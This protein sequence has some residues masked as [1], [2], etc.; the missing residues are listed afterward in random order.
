M[1]ELAEDSRISKK[2]MQHRLKRGW[3]VK[4]AVETPLT[5]KMKGV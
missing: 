4:R 1:I 5:T 2:A 3:S